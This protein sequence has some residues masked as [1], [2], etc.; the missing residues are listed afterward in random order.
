[1]TYHE[2]RIDPSHSTDGEWVQNQHDIGE[3]WADEG[4]LLSECSQN[5][6]SLYELGV[7]EL[8]DG[9]EDIRGSIHNQAGRIFGYFGD[10]GG[11]L[12]ARY[13]AIVEIEEEETEDD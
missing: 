6:G 8:P 9:L 3:G 12:L 4:D 5:V 13:F 7:D 10:S 1:M 11:E 2:S